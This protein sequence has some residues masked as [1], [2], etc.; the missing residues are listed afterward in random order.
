[1]FQ[2]LIVSLNDFHVEMK[3]F[4]LI[5]KIEL[6]IVLM[7]KTKKVVD[8][9]P[10]R[11]AGH[12]RSAA[13]RRRSSRAAVCSSIDLRSSCRCCRRSAGP[14]SCRRRWRFSSSICP[15]ATHNILVIIFLISIVIHVL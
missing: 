8:A 2:C 5:F 15:L 4:K 13:C 11:V 3:F 12:H 1:M 10:V 9:V 7:M 6:Q 14:T